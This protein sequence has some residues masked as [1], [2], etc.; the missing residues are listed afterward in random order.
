MTRSSRAWRCAWSRTR[1]E[2]SRSMLDSR[3]ACFRTRRSA[4]EEKELQVSVRSAELL[5]FEPL[6]RPSP[7][8]LPGDARA[9]AGSKPRF[10][11][12]RKGVLMRERGFRELQL[13]TVSAS[14][15]LSSPS[16]GSPGLVLSSVSAGDSG[17]LAAAAVRGPSALSENR[18]PT[19]SPRTKPVAWR[20]LTGRGAGPAAGTST[21]S[22]KPS[23][24]A[25]LT[26]A[27]MRA[28]DVRTAPVGV[29]VLTDRASCSS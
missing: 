7:A 20:A 15:W 16:S 19:S 24:V 1:S 11:A 26:P 5:F 17:R 4:T 6:R 25:K 21:T 2:I 27:S 22:T 29:R 8:S 28:S 23:P 12:E 13:E 10:V 18:T 9:P 3:L 14:L